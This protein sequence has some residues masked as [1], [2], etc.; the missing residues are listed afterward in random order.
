MADTE[1]LLGDGYYK[2]AWCLNIAN[3]AAPTV[4]ELNA[5][6]ELQKYI[7][8]DGLN[9]TSDQGEVDNSSLASTG[10]T[11]RGGSSTFNIELTCKIKKNPAENV[12]Q[13]TLVKG[14]MGFLAVRS[15]L[16]HTDAWAEGQRVK[17][18]PAECG[19]PNEPIAAPNEVQKFVSKIFNHSPAD[20]NAVVAA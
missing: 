9:I 5:G 14:Q 8:R 4:D 13:N 11:A 6:V 3:I 1:D 2:V 7:T 10:P 16:P 20:T 19:H 17:I 18:Y 12:A 15:N